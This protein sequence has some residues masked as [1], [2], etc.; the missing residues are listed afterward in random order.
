[1]LREEADDLPN[2]DPFDRLLGKDAI[3]DSLVSPHT[4]SLLKIPIPS[5]RLQAEEAIHEKGRD[6]E[7]TYVTEG[8]I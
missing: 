8:A 4:H 1:M 2:I 5:Y 3:G 7:E 6:D